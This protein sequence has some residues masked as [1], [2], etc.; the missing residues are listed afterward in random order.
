M[1]GKRS[2]GEGL[3]DLRPSLP[4][5]LLLEGFPPPIA[6]LA[7]ALR[8]VVLDTVPEAQERVRIGWRLIGYDLVIGRRSAFFAWIWPQVEHVHL[9]F[10]E[11]ILLDD[12]TGLMQGRGITK[13]ARWFTLVPGDPVEE[14]LSSFTRAAAQLA[15]LDRGERELLRL[16]AAD[17]EATERRP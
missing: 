4:P 10:P 15:R 3:P 13:R 2:L 8:R 9:G 12:P 16:M 11:G 7:Q 6:D 17:R 5:E 1:P 14:S